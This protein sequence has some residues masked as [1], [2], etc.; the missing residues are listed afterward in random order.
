M[1]AD[2]IDYSNRELVSKHH[3]RAAKIAVNHTPPRLPLIVIELV[4]QHHQDGDSD[5]DLVHDLLVAALPGRHPEKV[6][7][8]LGDTPLRP[9]VFELGCPWVPCSQTV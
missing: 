3:V 6:F 9:R 8:L 1:F 7:A 5:V 2:N 4:T